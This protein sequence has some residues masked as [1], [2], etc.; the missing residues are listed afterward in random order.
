MI[1]RIEHKI[2]NPQ[3]I[4]LTAIW[5]KDECLRAWLQDF[6]SELFSYPSEKEFY[7]E[8]VFSMN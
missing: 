5:I 2:F 6:Q 4:L 7:V 8:C 1:H 3:W